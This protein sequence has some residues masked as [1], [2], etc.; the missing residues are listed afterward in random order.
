MNEIVVPEEWI[1][2][3]RMCK[4]SF[5]NLCLQLK[6]LVEKNPYSCKWEI[7]SY[8]KLSGSKVIQHPVSTA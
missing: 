6:L 3:L 8:R 5:I 4:E 1:E 2:N 7:Y